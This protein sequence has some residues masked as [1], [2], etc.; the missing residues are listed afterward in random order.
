MDRA[1]HVALEA[2][3]TDRRADVRRALARAVPGLAQAWQAGDPAPVL[4]HEPGGERDDPG[5][6]RVLGQA[7]L[8]RRDPEPVPGLHRR[9]Q[10]VPGHPAPRL[11]PGQGVAL[12]LPGAR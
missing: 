3:R 4:V 2:D 7:G 11:A 6:L 9:L 5:L 12:T 1:A 8:G 10:P